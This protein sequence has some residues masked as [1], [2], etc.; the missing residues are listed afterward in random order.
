MATNYFELFPKIYYDVRKNDTSEYVLDLTRRFRIREVVLSKSINFYD[1]V[2]QN[3]DRPDIVSQKIYDTP[4]LDWLILMINTVFDPVWEWPMGYYD[5]RSYLVGKY[6]SYEEST[7]E[8]HHYEHIVQQ[9]EMLIDGTRI[10]KRVV[11]VDSTA[12]HQ[13]AEVDRRVV[14]MYDYENE[15]NELRRNI[16]LID[17][18]F[19]PQILDE[20]KTVL[21]I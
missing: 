3:E 12:Y 4:K 17:G 16:K 1:Y 19:L 8:V 15:L 18:A 6:G 20:A 13:I 5:F 14:S 2:V 10:P 7:Q 9:E 11:I 21:G